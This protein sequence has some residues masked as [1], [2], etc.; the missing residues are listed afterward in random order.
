MSEKPTSSS[1]EARRRRAGDVVT[2]V[3][4]PP[5]AAMQQKPKD[6]SAGP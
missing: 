3:E 5:G 4:G 1:R 2:F 6:Y